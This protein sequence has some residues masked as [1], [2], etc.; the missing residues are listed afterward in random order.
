M[1][2]VGLTSWFTDQ[3]SVT[4]CAPRGGDCG[5]TPT[6]ATFSARGWWPDSNGTPTITEGQL[7]G[8]K[9]LP[10]GRDLFTPLSEVVPVQIV[11]FPGGNEIQVSA[12]VDPE[13][14]ELTKAYNGISWSLV[15]PVG[16]RYMT[17]FRD[18][19]VSVGVKYEEE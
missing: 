12:I 8:R 14:M 3:A 5:T 10:N 1:L 19:Y 13:A 9:T 7:M 17:Q 18:L 6:S 15:N 16:D 4:V 2:S 11:S